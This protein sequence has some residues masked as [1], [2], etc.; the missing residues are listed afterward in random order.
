MS[1]GPTP[2][3]DIRTIVVA[4]PTNCRSVSVAVTAQGVAMVVALTVSVPW[5]GKVIGAPSWG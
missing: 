2:K 3:S 1:I 4:R 5:M